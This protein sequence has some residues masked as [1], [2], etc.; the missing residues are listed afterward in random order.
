MLPDDSSVQT[1]F[2]QVVAESGE[3]GLAQIEKSD[4][5]FPINQDDGWNSTDIKLVRYL[6]FGLNERG[7][8]KSGF[9]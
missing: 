1:D 6:L 2:S 3:G 5:A 8:R 9:L 7:E 4:C